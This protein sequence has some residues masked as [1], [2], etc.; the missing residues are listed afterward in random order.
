MKTKFN[1]WLVTLLILS[2][3]LTNANA[4]SISGNVSEGSRK[5]GYGNVDIFKGSKLIASVLTDKEGNFKVALDTGL[6]RC[7]ISYA[8]FEKIVKD[9]RVLGDETADIKMKADP[10]KMRKE[11]NVSESTTRTSESRKS[12]SAPKLRLKSEVMSAP[13]TSD[14]EVMPSSLTASMHRNVSAGALTAGEINDFSKWNLWENMVTKEL[15]HFQQLWNIAP[16]GRYTLVLSDKNGLP[17]ADAQVTLRNGKGVSEYTARTDNTGKAEC[18]VSL[19]KDAQYASE[20]F[21]MDVN[22]QG[23][24]KHIKNAQPFLKRM[25]YFRMEVACAQNN[26]VDIA[27]VVD[28]TG[29]MG[30]ELN[31]LKTEM[32]EI[33]FQSKSIS[34]TLNFRFGNVFY[35]DHGDEYLTRKMDFNRVLTE[36]SSFINDQNAGGGGDTPEAVEVALDSAINGLNWSAN[37]RARILFLILDAPPHGTSEIKNKLTDLLKQAAEKGIRIVPLAASGID[38]GTE[39]LMRCVALATNGSYVFL[40]NDSGIGGDHIKP[41]TDA[42]QVEQ[43]SQILVRVVKSYTYMPDCDQ[44]IPDLQLNYPDSIVQYPIHKD[45][46]DTVPSKNADSL[47]IEWSYY[48]NP[49]Q[50]IVNIVSNTDLKELYVTDLTGKVIQVLKNIRSR[51][52]VQ[53]DLEQY[54]TGIYLLRFPV[55]D[56]WLTGKVVVHHG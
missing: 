31:Y 53:V 37:A 23:S 49:T 16:T 20:S 1:F 41:T 48:P 54:P 56:K 44:Q 19:Q 35:R 33:I 13:T 21:T 17:L 4:Q 9:Y 3:N 12:T 27:F 11:I 43:L 7:E 15:T 22:Y 42:F 45:S 40:T 10:S 55:G 52:V 47:R 30:D 5:L 8:G 34:N 18:W 25:N 28:A 32:N 24:K 6:Y 14:M 2:V 38:K 50:G 26:D 36:S 39:Y 46:L 51:E 29:S